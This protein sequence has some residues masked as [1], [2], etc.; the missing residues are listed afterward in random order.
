LLFVLGGR[1]GRGWYTRRRQKMLCCL[2]RRRWRR[3]LA[4]TCLTVKHTINSWA[5]PRWTIVLSMPSGANIHEF[6][7]ADSRL[8]IAVACQQESDAAQLS[9]KCF[10]AVSDCTTLLKSMSS[11]FP[12]S[13]HILSS[14]VPRLVSKVTAF[15]ASRCPT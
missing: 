12:F 14:K 3:T 5:R 11:T 13:K 10:C 8:V 4:R 9:R 2:R 1:R 6:L 15:E 7:N